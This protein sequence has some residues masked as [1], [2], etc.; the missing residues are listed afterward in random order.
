VRR[1]LRNLLLSCA[2]LGSLLLPAAEAAATEF[3]DFCW[4]TDQGTVL[5][6]SVSQSGA[7]HYT[8]TGLFDDG[9][10]DGVSFAIL[11]VVSV[12]GNTLI[13]SFS[14]SKST[15]AKLKTGIWQLT[16]NASTFAGSAEGI[17]QSYDR[18]TQ[19]TSTDY[20]THALTL[21]P[22]L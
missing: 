2:T 5:R 1:G 13:G 11:G 14:G 3:G 6:F 7:S 4:L 12:T 8:Y 22:C 19:T 16:L 18:T 20:R 10:G 17:R 9:S 21:T 15:P